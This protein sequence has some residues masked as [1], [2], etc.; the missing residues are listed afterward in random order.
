[1]IKDL[2]M[3][4]RYSLLPFTK[5]ACT[6][7]SLIITSALSMPYFSATYLAAFTHSSRYCVNGVGSFLCACVYNHLF[8]SIL[9]LRFCTVIN[10]FLKDVISG[11][12]IELPLG[13]IIPLRLSQLGFLNLNTEGF[14][15]IPNFTCG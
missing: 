12:M 15:D 7:S 11:T 4:F 3:I 9:L 2:G 14:S 6:L 13:F 5:L 10:Y 1:M 8:Q